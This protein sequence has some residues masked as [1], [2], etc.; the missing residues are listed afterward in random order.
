MTAYTIRTVYLCCCTGSV[1]LP[2]LGLL[3]WTTSLLLSGCLKERVSENTCIISEYT[4][5]SVLTITKTR[6]N[7][8]CCW[9]SFTNNN[10]SH[11]RTDSQLVRIE[12]NLNT[13][14]NVL[15]DIANIFMALSLQGL[16][17][18]SAQFDFSPKTNVH[19]RYPP[20]FLFYAW[21]TAGSKAQVLCRHQPILNHKRPKILE[22]LQ[23]GRGLSRHRSLTTS[24]KLPLYVKKLKDKFANTCID[25]CWLGNIQN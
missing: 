7:P 19:S 16:L 6:C 1:L 12:G 14:E 17:S 23:H 18:L 8:E 9:G 22:I 10:H 13:W 15:R 21:K 25:P 24:Q 2:S 20:Y 4:G 3:C 11:I 5:T